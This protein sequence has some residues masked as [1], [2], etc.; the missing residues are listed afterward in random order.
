MHAEALFKKYEESEEE[1]CA[2]SGFALASEAVEYPDEALIFNDAW[3]HPNELASTESE[4][5]AMSELCTELLY[6]ISKKF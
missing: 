4:C 5:N 1:L 3:Y 6:I 2:F